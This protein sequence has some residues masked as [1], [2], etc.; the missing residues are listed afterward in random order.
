M[1]TVKDLRFEKFMDEA[2]IKKGVAEVAAR[3]NAL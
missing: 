2:Q 3:I 1:I